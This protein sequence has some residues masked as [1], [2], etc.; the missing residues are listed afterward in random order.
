MNILIT[1]GASGLGAAITKIFVKNKKNKVYFTYCNSEKEALDITSKFKNS[2]SIKCDYMC[3]N[4]MEKLINTMKTL[5]LDVLVNNAYSGVLLGTHFYKTDSDSF[6]NDFNKNIIPTIKITQQAIEGFR[7]KKSGKIITILTSALVNLPPIGSS[8]Y[9]AN[10]AY[11]KMLTKV[12]A[13]EYARFNISSNSIS[14]S[15]M[16]TKMNE[17]I[18]K[19]IVDQI[20]NEHPLKRLLT[21]EE[22]AEGVLYLT[23]TSNQVNGIDIVMNAGAN[24]R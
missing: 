9:I 22:V 2:F 3:Q 12:W 20:I 19:R 6:I 24:I 7:K 18:D 13:N 4:D 10:K 11:M 21:K 1:G 23:H 17:N 15:F 5:D 8:I 16:Q 14:P